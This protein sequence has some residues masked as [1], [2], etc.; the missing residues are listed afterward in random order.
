MISS[1]ARTVNPKLVDSCAVL[2]FLRFANHTRRGGACRSCLQAVESQ[3]KLWQC[4][5]GLEEEVLL[6]DGVGD[7]DPG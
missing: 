4:R 1:T 7:Y 2:I 3:C 6:L 5:P